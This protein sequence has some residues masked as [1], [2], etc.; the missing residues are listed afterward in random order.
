MKTITIKQ[1]LIKE[2]N[3]AVIEETLRTNP[4]VGRTELSRF[5]CEKFNF[6]DRLGKLQV[7]SCQKA[8]YEL[9]AKGLI[10]LPDAKRNTIPGNW[11]PKRLE[12][13]IPEPENVPESVEHICSV[14]LILVKAK[15][16]MEMKIHNELICSEHP[17]GDKRIAGRQLRYLIKSEHGFLGAISFSSAALFLEDRDKWIGWQGESITENRDYIINMSRFLIRNSIKC[18]N[19]ASHILGKCV[20]QVPD[21][22][23]ARYGY[24]PLIIETFVD[25]EHYKGTCYKA[26][27]WILCS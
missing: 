14:D 15:N 20:K 19:L 18:K 10:S 1:A 17:L 23:E 22:F 8:L 2:K 21:D 25:T 4:S 11:S 24:R 3:L 16:T 5:L 12:H 13:A 7:S 6:K 27:N 9:D 26:S